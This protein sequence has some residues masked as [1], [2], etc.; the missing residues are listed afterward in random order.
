MAGDFGSRLL[1]VQRLADD[2]AVHGVIAKGQDRSAIFLVENNAQHAAI[3]KFDPFVEMALG[4]QG[5][6][7]AGD[8]A[9]VLAQFG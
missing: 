7:G 3:F 2:P 5:V 9:G 4:A 6:E 8:G 1:H